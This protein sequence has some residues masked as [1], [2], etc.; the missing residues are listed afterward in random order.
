MAE[1]PARLPRLRVGLAA[2]VLAKVGADAAGRLL[3]LLLFVI[4]ARVLPID[5]FGR[6]AFALAVGL[7]LAQLSDAGL[8]FSLLRRLAGGLAG[9][10]A[11]HAV[12]TALVARTLVTVPL[13]LLVP[14]LA[15]AAGGSTVEM[16]AVAVVM[17]AAIASGYA[18]LLAQVLRA[19]GRL[20]LEAGIWMTTRVALVAAGAAALASGTGLAGLAAAHLL[21]AAGAVVTTTAVVRRFIEPR[22]PVGPREVRAALT[23]A[24]PVAAALAASLLM[25]RIDIVLLEWL[26]GPESV[27]Q[28]STAFRLFEA[29]LIVPA[30]VMAA[31]FPAL[32][33][34]VPRRAPLRSV[35]VRTGAVL[36][37]LGVTVALAAWVAGPAL[38]EL[39]FGDRYAGAGVLLR[40]LA[41]AIPV[42]FLNSLLT[43]ALIAIGRAWRQAVAM[44]LALL[45]NVGLNLLLIPAYD[46]AGAAI[47]T[48]AA[49]GVLLAGCLVAL[50][51][52][53]R[54]GG[55]PRY[56]R[57][58]DSV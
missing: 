53:L 38:L 8:Q 27:A 49:E 13:A 39:L 14:P 56:L 6:Y 44:A 43:Q 45:V 15:I 31:A 46:A 48:V 40:V 36:V 29:S 11:A 58:S 22:R 12:G 17:L 47:A 52:P 4:A 7:L 55:D 34:A 1:Q 20:E 10:E 30:A 16:V 26:R 54:L 51:S 5:S 32:V 3:Q 28:Y 18:D 2:G 42:M 33:R 9:E 37:A 24:L 19:A 25:F 35:G 21:A 57:T 23:A 50:A 41:V